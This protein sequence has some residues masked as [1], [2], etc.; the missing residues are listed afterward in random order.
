MEV[1][2]ANRIAAGLVCIAATAGVAAATPGI[3]APPEGPP[4]APRSHGFM[5]YLSQPVGGGAGAALH[6]K[7]GFRIEQVRM[8]GNSGA[9]DAGDPLQHRALIGWQVDGLRGMHVSDGKV[10]LGGRMTYDVAHG[11]FAAQLPKTSTAAA[12][13]PSTVGRTEVST[14]S[15]P[16]SS[17]LFEPG[18]EMRDPFR[19]SVESA[20]MV[21]DIAAAAIGSFKLS[22]PV[23]A[24]QRVGTAE[25]PVSMRGPN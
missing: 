15:K 6:P 5:L 17:H 7:F 13:R 21:H 9:P 3:A 2:A 11:V 24:Q 1:R 20:S 16:F 18:N 14:E 4:L 10:D 19:Q 12:S 23:A 8:M 22:R 25:R